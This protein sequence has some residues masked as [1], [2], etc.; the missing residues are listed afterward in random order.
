GLCAT[1]AD[2]M[3]TPLAAVLLLLLF[4]LL[5]HADELTV[6][7]ED[8]V[9]C[10]PREMLHRYLLKECQKHF[11]ARRQAIA[12]LKTPEDVKRRQQELRAKFIESLGGFPAKTPLNPKVVGTL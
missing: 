8:L 10:P 6:L 9:G 2:P 4:S 5:A 3:R 7:T 11:D 12:A 1:G